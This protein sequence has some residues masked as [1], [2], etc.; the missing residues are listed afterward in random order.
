MNLEKTV[1]RKRA[2]Q[3]IE[4]TNNLWP[5]TDR[6]HGDNATKRTLKPTQL[7]FPG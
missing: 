7:L 5:E 4:N 3:G 2:W 1:A 6:Q